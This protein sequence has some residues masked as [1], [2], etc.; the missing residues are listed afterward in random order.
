MVVVVVVVGMGVVIG[1]LF[2]VE[3]VVATRIGIRELK[4]LPEF[5]SGFKSFSL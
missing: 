2:G 3:V 5:V 1:I 4:F